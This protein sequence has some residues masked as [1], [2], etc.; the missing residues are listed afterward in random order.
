MVKPKTT[1]LFSKNK[2]NDC[3]SF[4]LS[5]FM[6]TMAMN[7]VDAQRLA[8]LIGISFYNFENTRHRESLIGVLQREKVLPMLLQ[9]CP[10]KFVDYLG[11]FNP[12]NAEQR[13]SL[14]TIFRIKTT[15]I[16]KEE[17]V[18]MHMAGRAAGQLYRL[19]CRFNKNDPAQNEALTEILQTPKIVTWLNNKVTI[20][21]PGSAPKAP[22]LELF[23][24][25]DL[26]H[27]PRAIPTPSN[28]V[29]ISPCPK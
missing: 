5:E 14:L 27:R 10:E 20:G 22:H 9:H 28:V 7:D 21:L 26:P 13:K 18:L 23:R 24:N 2:D 1:Q 29:P 25:L 16:G 4:S 3:H 15:V 6:K 11:N 19:L 12:A 17:S 8:H